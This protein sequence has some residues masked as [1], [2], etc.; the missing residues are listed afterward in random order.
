MVARA[1]ACLW[2]ALS[3]AALASEA[4]AKPNIILIMADDVGYEC[5]GCYGSEQYETPHIDRMAAEGIRFEHC[6]SQPLCT[7]SRVKIMTGLSNVRNYSAFSVLNRDQRTFAHRFKEAG[8]ATFVGGKWQLLGAEHYAERFRGKGSWPEQAGFDRCCLW[9]VDR[10]GERYWNPLLYIDGQNRQFAPEEYGP[11]IVTEH[12]LKFMQENRDRPFFIYYPMIL[13]HDPFEPTPDSDSREEKN[14]TQNFRDMVH[15]A[16]KI[17]GRIIAETEALGIAQETLILFVG[18]NGTH[19]GIRSTLHGRTV[20]GGKGETTDAGTR[21]PLVAY[22]PGTVPG[23]V[24]NRDLIDFSDFVPTFQEA[25]GAVTPAELD[26]VSFAPQ[27]RGE[28]GTPR[29]WM[30]C[31]YNPRPEKSKPQ[32]FVRDQRWKL[33]G[34]G[35]FYDVEND[36]LEQ[37]PLQIR[38]Q[39]YHKLAAALASMPAEGQTLLRFAD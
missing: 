4:S 31:Y 5:F 15:Y 21:V 27:L 8:Y 35:R 1:L 17:V 9:Q 2:I 22:Q 3:L 36:P 28:A 26:G 34:D 6:Y 24:V 38:N 13:V 30:Y 14:K 25:I 18:D 37:E 16:D 20:R 29:P 11:E 39:A 10:L 19:R 23:G 33:Y 32:R 12:L 7:P